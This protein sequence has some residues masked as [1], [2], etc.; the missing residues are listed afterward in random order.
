MYA[1]VKALLM[2]KE[3]R[4]GDCESEEFYS[5]GP[6][7]WETEGDV[8]NNAIEKLREFLFSEESGYNDDQVY[9]SDFINRAR[10]L[11]ID[12]MAPEVLTCRLIRLVRQF[13]Q[14]DPHEHAVIALVYGKSAAEELG[15]FMVAKNAVILETTLAGVGEA[16]QIL[17]TDW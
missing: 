16:D 2:S 13:V 10:T 15:N 8:R 1:P 17:S 4:I 9:V 3:D 5:C 12:L 14:D 6:F 11:F 7:D